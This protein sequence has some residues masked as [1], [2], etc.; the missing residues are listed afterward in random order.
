M[1]AI[2]E[3]SDQLVNAG[4][5]E[6]RHY[7]TNP[8]PKVTCRLA[9]TGAILALVF[10]AAPGLAQDQIVLRNTQVI[11]KPILSFDED[12]V[13]I[14]G[15]KDLGWDEIESATVG[16][17]QKRFNDL[18]NDLGPNLFKVRKRLENGDYADLLDFAKGL[19]PR[20]AGRR[21]ATAYMV[22]QSLMWAYLATGQREAAVE[23]YLVCLDYLPTQKVVALPGTRRLRW[24][25]ATGLSPELAP[26]WF[27]AAAAKKSLP[28]VEKTLG[29]VSKTIPGGAFYYGAT[30]ALSA[31][32]P[33][34]A[35]K[36]LARMPQ[37]KTLGELALIARAQGEILAGKEGPSV[38]ALA[39]QCSSV[40][41]DCHPL[42]HYWL[43]LAALR[44][45]DQAKKKE[46]L[47]RMLYLPAL[48]GEQAPDLSAAALHL[49][50]ETLEAAPA[51]KN[52]AGRLRTE[53]LTQYPQTY[54]GMRLQAKLEVKEKKKN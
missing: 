27:D 51:T 3:G 32:Q 4:C 46:G 9:W 24:E 52:Q 11:K 2:S 35:D 38:K 33:D 8:R 43:G 48:Y 25:P 45:Q 13:K 10:M 18:L 7:L 34:V 14:K 6:K 23:P 17:N 5:R 42:A 26:I 22:S 30:L 1:S 15:Q 49:A 37:D 21:S 28:A 40:H 41:S 54:H 12:G 50:M 47:L 39:K 16:S 44:S 31:G 19:F 53:L 29:T 20:Y 36:L